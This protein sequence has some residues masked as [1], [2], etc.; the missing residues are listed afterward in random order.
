MPH[1]K[2]V[3][4]LNF[5]VTGAKQAQGEL[6]KITQQI[7]S[8][9][10]VPPPTG[11]G[12][13]LKQ[14]QQFAQ[15]P[16]AKSLAGLRAIGQGWSGITT[17]LS[18]IGRINRRLDMLADS[19]TTVAE[20]L[21][22]AGHPRVAKAIQSAF[23]IRPLET[24]I[25]LFTQ[26]PKELSKTIEEVSKIRVR[27][28]TLLASL[29]DI[30]KRFN[31][32]RTYALSAINTI[33]QGF[34]QLGRGAATQVQSVKKLALETKL[35]PLMPSAKELTTRLE[36]QEQAIS[37]Y[38]KGLTGLIPVMNEIGRPERAIML[39]N[40]VQAIDD[41]LRKISE[42]K[43]VL[44]MPKDVTVEYKQNVGRL[45][46]ANNGLIK[47]TQNM[48]TTSQR[49]E[50]LA[51][52]EKINEAFGQ[53]TDTYGA[54]IGQ[55]IRSGFRMAA[56][57]AGTTAMFTA[58]AFVSRGLQEAAWF[59]YNAQMASV[60][61]GKS[62]NELSGAFS[63]L[64]L[65][66]AMTGRDVST[67]ARLFY[68]IS[69]V[70]KIGANA[71]QDLARNLNIV[72]YAYMS[73]LVS[74]L[75]FEEVERNFIPI[76]KMLNVEAQDVEKVFSFLA[77]L[78]DQTGVSADYLGQQI[79]YLGGAFTSFSALAGDSTKAYQ[80]RMEDF[81]ITATTV[82][83]MQREMVAPDIMERMSRFIATLSDPKAAM[84]LEQLGLRTESLAAFIK[85]L[86]ELKIPTERL[87]EFAEYIAS[88]AGMSR[89]EAL[90]VYRLLQVIREV[91]KEMAKA[92]A[93][94]TYLTDKFLKSL[95]TLPVQMNVFSKS[96]Q[97]LF[98]NLSRLGAVAG[99]TGLLN[100]INSI[101]L[102]LVFIT[103]KFAEWSERV[104]IIN[105]S[106]SLTLGTITA[107]VTSLATLP[108]I[109]RSLAAVSTLTKLLGEVAVAKGIEQPLLG[110]MGGGIEAFRVNLLQT[111]Q[112]ASA[113]EHGI[114]AAGATFAVGAMISLSQGVIEAIETEKPV[115]WEKIGRS[116]GDTILA[117]V[118]T[119]V[120]ITLGEIAI[121]RGLPLL[122]G[123]GAWFAGL[124]VG[125]QAIIIGVI[126]TLI[127]AIIIGLNYAKTGKIDL[128]KTITYRLL[129]GIGRL[130]G[131]IGQAFYDQIA[132]FYMRLQADFNITNEKNLPKLRALQKSFEAQADYY[133][134]EYEKSLK[135][136]P[137]PALK[138]FEW[139]YD[140][141]EQNASRQIS[142]LGG[143]QKPALT[144][145]QTKFGKHIITSIEEAV[146]LY[147][148]GLIGVEDVFR[149][150]AQLRKQIDEKL[151]TTKRT[152]EV[153]ELL[154]QRDDALNQLIE[155]LKSEAE[156][157]SS[158]ILAGGRLRVVGIK[159][160]V[161]TIAN[162][163]KQ[164]ALGQIDYAGYLKAVSELT[165]TFESNAKQLASD[166]TT[167]F[168]ATHQVPRV[169]YNQAVRMI[170]TLLVSAI[171]IGI[172][173]GAGQRV[174]A[175][176]IGLIQT[177]HQAGINIGSEVLQV[178]QGML[179]LGQGMITV[180]QYLR[181]IGA[182]A[183]RILALR[184]IE[185]NL[186]RKLEM[187][188]PTPDIY[189]Q[190]L[191]KI[192]S[193]FSKIKVQI[194]SF[195]GGGGAGR[196]GRAAREQKELW[197]RLS[198]Q[199]SYYTTLADWSIKALTKVFTIPKSFISKYVSALKAARSKALKKGDYDKATQI[200]KDLQEVI[201]TQADL[202]KRIVE[203]RY[204]L[205]LATIRDPVQKAK[206][207]WQKALAEFNIVKRYFQ[208]NS[209]EW[210]RA[211]S[212]VYQAYR[213][214]IDA[215]VSAR[216]ENIEREA[217]VKTLGFISDTTKTAIELEK[218]LR[219]YQLVVRYYGRSSKEAKDLAAQL[220]EARFNLLRTRLQE[221]E[222][223]LEKQV[224]LGLVSSDLLRAFYERMIAL[225][226]LD[227]NTQLEYRRKLKDLNEKVA[228]SFKEAIGLP[229]VRVPTAQEVQR[230]L[231][232]QLFQNI[233]MSVNVSKDVDVASLLKKISEAMFGTQTAGQVIA[234]YV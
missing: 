129:K 70:F 104:P 201:Q 85:S 119:G 142:K 73:A 183:E 169:L 100:V 189:L 187:T 230:A 76:L 37:T 57:V 50:K 202:A 67:A 97:M 56:F 82:A 28:E 80:Q 203:R 43:K 122:A 69:Q 29:D 152:Q 24:A 191:K 214:Y 53:I 139:W 208:R 165:G 229:E 113:Y 177:F 226:A 206:V 192:Q 195:R 131:G 34:S 92:S 156:N 42:A 48:I 124:S 175:M 94:G 118:I 234:S 207:E 138:I 168:E 143:I 45:I 107:I 149:A 125:I 145:V 108:T 78:Q 144:E 167:I 161:A 10:K 22:K 233:Q 232:G 204:D 155:G 71:S 66:A 200:T 147:K 87:S 33:S 46:Q 9:V 7:Y 163:Q 126:Y 14:A 99:F 40:Q 62:T 218:T 141:L 27:P 47:S 222:S 151:K 4:E 36:S 68:E 49:L 146:S 74:G 158:Q 11:I 61:L 228:Q 216:K 58:L 54:F 86:A 3:I 65:I 20:A 8:G 179:A 110:R 127:E 211:Y 38:K 199:W 51:G 150:Y 91:P 136:I 79:A 148:G 166:I 215:L 196:A 210:V 123:L 30:G 117:S 176:V 1:I 115:N 198:E 162:L 128:T 39:A 184:R 223:I 19:T 157:I 140:L 90:F 75:S 160:L 6:Q 2:E 231:I 26:T 209:E 213:S 98:V 105:Q 116:L 102:G 170:A 182:S 112:R 12:D 77:Y 89:R 52:W 172:T 83:L 111:L 225:N 164:L 23:E 31:Y 174:Y 114:Y 185:A 181:Q 96:I 186:G 21:T 159:N 178:A 180:E 188:A 109:L 212:E 93:Q 153:R 72:K 120:G 227:L 55:M 154:R 60:V 130:L 221:Q 137:N 44:A 224:D 18:G 95:Q 81:K 132:T 106:L 59:Q 219:E 173:T 171:R 84:Q 103:G 35:A 5:I 13:F 41:Q 101:V 88:I 194:P 193:D 220:A 121:T 32:A 64:G 133:A 134:K 15:M 205:R 17:S 135:T 16:Y 25:A 217:R 190:A 197:E 63:N